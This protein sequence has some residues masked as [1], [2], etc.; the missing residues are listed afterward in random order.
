VTGVVAL[1]AS[2][3][4]RAVLDASGQPALIE[5]IATASW[6][7]APSL[8]QAEVGNALWKYRR[9]GM[10]DAARAVERHAEAIGLVHRFTDDAE[11]FPEALRLAVSNDQPVYDAMYLVTARRHAACL[12]TFDRRLHAQ[13]ARSQVDAVLFGG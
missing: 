10:L 4:L 6:I 1:D 12:L 2:A 8:L 7:V 9:A 13:C 11:L 5:R 3:A